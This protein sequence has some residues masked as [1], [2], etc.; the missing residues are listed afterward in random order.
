MKSKRPYTHILKNLL[1]EQAEEIVPVL[2]P[3]LQVIQVLDIEMPE[4]RSIPLEGSPSEMD[5]GLV[6][7]LMPGAEVVK[8]YKTEWIE[9]SGKFE[10]AYRV[11]EEGSDEP[12]VL[13]IEFQ[14]ERDD[15]KLPRRLLANFATVMRKV[16]EDFPEDDHVVQYESGNRGT[17]IAYDVYPE[18]LC[19]FPSA[20]PEHIRDEI[21]GRVMMEFK[22]K[23]IQLWEMDAREVLN[24]HVSAAY[25]LLPAMK[26][27]DAD[28]LGLAINELAQ[29]FQGNDAELGRHLTGLNMML[30]MS[31]TMT[32]EQKSAV[33]EHLRPFAHLVK[34]DPLDE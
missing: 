29:R 16:K 11:K 9:H 1:H 7:L 19:P 34:D 12:T 15:K 5:K 18:V 10:R 8:A 27:A 3:G 23:R 24:T 33:Q 4:L 20:I 22:F 6:G 30:Q 17:V 2:E 28:L 25:F 32:D 31:E 14:M 26:N 21:G 13:M